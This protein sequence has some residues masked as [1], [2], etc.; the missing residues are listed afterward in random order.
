MAWMVSIEIWLWKKNS[1]LVGIRTKN[2]D[3]NFVKKD[4]NSL[5]M[6]EQSSEWMNEMNEYSAFLPK[7]DVKI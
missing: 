3:S 1:N 5:K 6:N 7:K 2:Y 4:R